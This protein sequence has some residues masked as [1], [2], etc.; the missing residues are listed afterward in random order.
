MGL[1]AI[2]LVA[3]LPMFLSMLKSTVVIKQQTQAKNLTQERLEQVRDL[4][5]HVANQNG[6]YLDLLDIYYTDARWPTPGRAFTVA[7]T[8]WRAST[9]PRAVGRTAS[10]SR[11]TTASP[12]S[13]PR[14]DGLQPGRND[15]VPRVGRQDRAA[16]SEVRRL[17]QP[18][19]RLSTRPPSQTSASP[20]VTR[21]TEDGRP[22]ELPHLHA[23]HGDATG[24]P[25]IQ[26]QARAVAVEV[27][28]DGSRRDEPGAAGRASPRSTA[29]SP[30][31]S[32][33]SGYAGGALARRTGPPS[34]RRPRAS[35]SRTTR[36]AEAPGTQTH[37]PGCS[38]YGL[39]QQLRRQRVRRDR[40]RLPL[41]P[42]N[43][44][45][46]SSPPAS[47]HWRR[48]EQRC[49]TG[50]AQL[51]QTRVDAGIRTRGTRR[52]PHGRQPLVR[53]ADG[54]SGSTAL[55]GS[56][57]VTATPLTTRIPAAHAPAAARMART[58]PVV[59]SRELPDRADSGW[60]RRR[61]H[62][63]PWT[64]RPGHR[65]PWRRLTPSS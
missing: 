52:S 43:V 51:H 60:S 25:V 54:T 36:C 64:A 14:C 38:W 34:S 10:R 30:A 56:A 19:A 48:H 53:M 23:D 33:V 42:I 31:G 22:Q 9:S 55:A 7:L 37:P 29:R 47:S 27:R 20:V 16:G 6:P 3:S 63:R 50:N 2:V 8:A 11:P 61:S 26:S 46:G 21:W 5:F 18:A 15:T 41:S 59:L 65:A 28:L 35:S 40:G 12:S 49:N 13:P 32:A 39:R 45:D 17:Q 62:P 24:E 44:D 58:R 57:Y 1:L 4:R